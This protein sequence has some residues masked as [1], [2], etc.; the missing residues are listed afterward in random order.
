MTVS[1]GGLLTWTPGKA[2]IG[3]HDL[4][5]RVEAGGEMS[6]LRHQLEV[7]PA[8]GAVACVSKA[9]YESAGTLSAGDSHLAAAFDPVNIRKR[10]A[11][12]ALPLYPQDIAFHPMLDLVAGANGKEI[13][14]FS[15]RTGKPAPDRLDVAGLKLEGVRQIQFSPGGRRL[16]AVCMESDGRRVLRSFP[17]KVE[18]LEQAVLAAGVRLPAVQ[19]A[20]SASDI[21]PAPHG[22][23]QA[24]AEDLQALVRPAAGKELTPREIG[25]LYMDSVVILETAGGGATG[26]CVGSQGYILTCAHALSRLGEPIVSYRLRQGDQVRLAKARAQVVRLDAENDLALLRIAPKAAMPPV[27]LGKASEIEAGESVVVIGHPGL[28]QAMLNYTMTTGIVSNP[29]QK[30]EGVSYVQTNAAVNPGSSGGPVFNDRG[31]LIGLVILKGDIESAGFAVPADRI[32]LFLN[33]CTRP[34]K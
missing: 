3:K 25:R 29:R 16:L 2:D 33:S 32:E 27:H 24:G 14:V 28:G 20:D 5:I 7:V 30:L 4:K 22:A 18:E 12:Y 17:L 15:R 10:I 8:G 26:V 1:A 21:A 31:L 6:F 34:A 19:A 13:R 9:G 23:T 11:L